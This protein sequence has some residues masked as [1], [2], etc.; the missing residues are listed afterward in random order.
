MAWAVTVS[1]AAREVL[2]CLAAFDHSGPHRAPPMRRLTRLTED[3]YRA[4]L[5]ELDR[6]G[7]VRLDQDDLWV[8]AL[9]GHVADA[10]FA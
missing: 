8:T 10:A 3:A 6:L 7:L 1:P 2:G 9:G 5:Q 4:A